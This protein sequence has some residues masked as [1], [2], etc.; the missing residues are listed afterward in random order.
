VLR[1]WGAGV[2]FVAELRRRNV[3]RMGGLYLVGA[4]LIVQVCAT[5]LPVFDAPAWLMRALVGVLGIGFVV[6]M[7]VS[8]LFE[9]TPEGL[10]RDVEVNAGE[11]MP[12]HT[13]RQMDR[14]MDRLIISVLAL[15]LVYFAFDKFVLAPARMV[16]ARMVPATSEAAAAFDAKSPAAENAGAVSATATSSA[17]PVAKPIVPGVA[18][19]PFD[20]LS[21]D[22]D[23][24]YFAGGMHEEVL[25]KLSRIGELRVISRTS[26]ERIAE[27][28]LEVGTISQRLGVSHVLEGSVR[29]AGDQIRV[30]V[31]LIEAANDNHVWAENYDRKLD[32]VFA[33]QSE[34]ALA[35]ADQLKLTLSSELKANLSERPTTNQAAYALYLRALEERR[36]WRREVGFQSMIDLLEPAVA[37]DP[38]FLE[39]RVKL[40]GAYGRMAWLSADPDGEFE[41]K[42]RAQVESIVARWPEHPQSQIAR[43]QLIVN[44]QRDY[45]QA[46]PH[47]EVARLNLPNDVDVLASISASMKRLGRDAEFLQFARRVVALDPESPHA[48]AELGLALLANQQLDEAVTTMAEARTRFADNVSIVDVWSRA[49]LARDQ[50]ISAMTQNQWITQ[51]TRP[52]AA[53]AHFVQGDVDALLQP[54]QS[55]EFGPVGRI[56]AAATRAE[57]LHLAGRTADAKRLTDEASELLDALYAAGTVR[58]DTA[59]AFTHAAAAQIAALAGDSARARELLSLAQT[60]PPFDERHNFDATLS[61]TMR[62]LGDAEAA[63]LLLQPYAGDAFTLSHGELLAF[64]PFYDRVYGESPSY[65][66]YMAKIEAERKSM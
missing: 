32:D 1:A 52:A 9:L 62:Q 28:K 46:L 10:K 55:V 56:M 3:I 48:T 26:M 43:G 57:L 44:L 30:T 4:W 13:A 22:P 39:A 18:V 66:A 49:K 25:T 60:T 21:P 51:S 14:R 15:A 63:W 31:Q 2:S 33:I 29:R 41:R 37:A 23:N 40:A 50:D 6:A 20:N 27:E 5:L 7:V 34:I 24:A 65:R 42:A 8:W 12:P 38:N 16:P 64:R 19:L 11:P 45:L 58:S 54:I 17:D 47:F 53:I 61:A 36:V 59:K 35:I